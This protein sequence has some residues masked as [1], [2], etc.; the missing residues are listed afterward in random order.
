MKDYK[1]ISNPLTM[2]GIFAG[3][4][5]VAG[6]T[7]L[8]F[9]TGELQNIFIWYV[10]LFPVLLVVL[11]FI[12]LIFKNDALYAPC[13]FKD[14]DHFMKLQNLQKSVRQIEREAENVK[15]AGPEFEK[16]IEPVIRSVERVSAEVDDYSKDI[17][18]SRNRKSFD[19]KKLS[20]KAR[21]LVKDMQDTEKQQTLN[22]ILSFLGLHGAK[23]LEQ[24]EI[25]R[26]LVQ[27]GYFIKVENH[28]QN[29]SAGD[30]IYRAAT[31]EEEKNLTWPFR[32]YD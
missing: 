20:N 19:Y 32:D 24:S 30:C 3:I 1:K 9:V 12:T 21:E 28:M 2:I 25:L 16:A 10:M 27:G 14:E 31:P 22:D 7:V 26:R 8:P 13:D 5:E 29:N 6:T 4:A 15:S 18:E 11:F 17:I 23:T